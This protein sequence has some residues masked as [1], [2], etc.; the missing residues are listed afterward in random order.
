MSSLDETFQQK[1][2]RRLKDL[3]QILGIDIGSF[4]CAQELTAESIN[5]AMEINQLDLNVDFVMAEV[6]F[7]HGIAV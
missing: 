2:D 7:L 4:T 5:M 1:Y 6:T 3:G